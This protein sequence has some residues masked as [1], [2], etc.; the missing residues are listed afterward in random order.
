[1][2]NLSCRHLKN[3]HF[4]GESTMNGG[5]ERDE[6]GAGKRE[7]GWHRTIATAKENRKK[8]RKQNGTNN[9]NPKWN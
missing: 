6:N 9:R 5:T 3:L 1:M 7:R 2:L 8:T 4:I